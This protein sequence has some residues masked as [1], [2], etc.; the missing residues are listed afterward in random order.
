M[1]IGRRSK[2]DGLVRS[3]GFV[4]RVFGACGIVGFGL[5]LGL[6]SRS[7]GLGDAVLERSDG[8]VSDR[9]GVGNIRKVDA[10][11]ER[12]DELYML[13]VALKKLLLQRESIALEADERLASGFDLFVEVGENGV[14]A[15]FCRADDS[16]CALLRVGFYLVCGA[17]CVD[18][19]AAYRILLALYLVELG[20]GALELAL[21]L[22]VL[23]VELGVFADKEFD[24]FVD[25]DGAVA[26][27]GAGKGLV[28]EFM[29]W[30]HYS[31]SFH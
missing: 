20:D 13:A 27:H 30:E 5:R 16:F 11:G 22:V 10:L 18:E 1:K 23:A 8:F 29:R 9:V 4:S 31:R 24:V 15:G 25:L 7:V 21:K 14:A 19:S 3:G 28:F 12:V 6:G 2:G 26:S 17:L